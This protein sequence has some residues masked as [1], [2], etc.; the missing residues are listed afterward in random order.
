MQHFIPLHIHWLSHAGL[1]CCDTLAVE[2]LN[3]VELLRHN[4]TP[5]EV[6]LALAAEDAH[7]Q[8]VF[9][10][11]GR[12]EP[13]PCGSGRTYKHSQGDKFVALRSAQHNLS[14]ATLVLLSSLN[15]QPAFNTRNIICPPLCS[16]PP[17]NGSSASS[18]GVSRSI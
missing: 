15:T 11:A 10:K 5:A 7:L 14:E 3:L 2:A 18:I 12:N 4:R 8:K 1:H 13:Y 16:Y 6:M 9:A 17:V